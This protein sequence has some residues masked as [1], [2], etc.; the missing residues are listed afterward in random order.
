MDLNILPKE[1]ISKIFLYLECPVAK[2]VKNEIKIYETDHNWD[3][4]KIYRLYYVK[5]FMDFSVY[6]FDKYNEPFDYM[7]YHNRIE[8]YDNDD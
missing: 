8:Y 3:L 1:V 4:T 5:N 6:Y 7:S 2:L